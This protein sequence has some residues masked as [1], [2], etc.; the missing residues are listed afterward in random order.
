MLIMW[1]RPVKEKIQKSKIQ[2]LGPNLDR[3]LVINLLF[4]E[5]VSLQ[6]AEGPVSTCQSNNCFLSR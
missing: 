2:P 6:G 1:F 3:M 4:L 5:P